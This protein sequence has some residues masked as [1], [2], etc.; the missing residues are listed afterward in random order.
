MMRCRIYTGGLVLAI[1]VCGCGRDTPL[2]ASPPTVG[3]AAVPKVVFTD[4]RRD[5]DPFFCA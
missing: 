3:E 2:V 5:G 4:C 1:L